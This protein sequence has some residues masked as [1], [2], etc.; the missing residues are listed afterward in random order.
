M[1]LVE[2]DVPLY[3]VVVEYLNDEILSIPVQ[4]VTIDE[5]IL[6][7]DPCF[8]SRIFLAST[9]CLMISKSFLIHIFQSRTFLCSTCL[10]IGISI[11]ITTGLTTLVIMYF[12][13]SRSIFTRMLGT[14]GSSIHKSINTQQPRYLRFV[15]I[16]Y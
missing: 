2:C 4:H 15:L 9:C 5:Q 3:I 6:L 13:T 8:H 10:S 12:S 11:L 14:M 1:L 7:L 16:F